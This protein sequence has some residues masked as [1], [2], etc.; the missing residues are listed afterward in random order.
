MAR[1][2]I[3]EQRNSYYDS[4]EWRKIRG[5]V[6]RKAFYRCLRC[7]QRLR[8]EYLSAH[9]MIP[10][11]K[12]GADEFH[13]LVCLCHPCH[14]FVEVYALGT[15]AAIIGSYA[16]FAVLDTEI[17]P[18]TKEVEMG[19]DWQTWVYGGLKKARKKSCPETDSVNYRYFISAEDWEKYWEIWLRL[20]KKSKKRRNLDI[21]VL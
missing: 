14:D 17:A 10:R 8:S 6:L 4:E 5:E 20:P 15:K 13:N 7:N 3:I 2:R 12:G 18:R 19:V 21:N 1:I 16:L 11:D 9:H